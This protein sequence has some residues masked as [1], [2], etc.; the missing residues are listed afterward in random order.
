MEILKTFMCDDTLFNVNIIWNKNEPLI[1]ALDVGHILQ[2][3]DINT[4]LKSENFDQ[5]EMIV[6]N[7]ITYVT[8][9]G[10]FDLHSMT[11]T[12]TSRK[13]VMWTMDVFKSIQ[14]DV[15][16]Q[17]IMVIKSA[18]DKK[19]IKPINIM[20]GPKLQIY[21]LITKQLVHTFSCLIEATRDNMYM[22]GS[23]KPMI[24]NAIEKN[25]AYKNYQW[26]SL[27]RD[28]PDDSVQVL[29]PNVIQ[30]SSVNIGYIAMLDLD[31]KVIMQVFDS[32]KTAGAARKLKG[33]SAIS[34]AITRQSQSTGHY[35]MMWN[36]CDQALKDAFLVKNELP[37]K[38]V[39]VNGVP[40]KQLHPITREII[41]TFSCTEEVIREFHFGRKTLKEAI[42][43]KNIAKGFM[44]A[45]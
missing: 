39:R 30:K 27:A 24:K 8:D 32:M 14:K 38:I 41:K 34:N 9:I 17:T 19:G 44:W 12:L 3:E 42:E 20:R 4:I 28:L 10:L 40:I 31:K 15:Q 13:F 29:P 7:D 22:A 21:D 25:I 11:H 1:C 18:S 45:I 36:D 35:W 43:Y 33:L 37:D 23:S 16:Q 2:M 6:I 26:M 5:N